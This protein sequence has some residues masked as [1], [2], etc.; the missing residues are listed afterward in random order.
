MRSKRSACGEIPVKIFLKIEILT[1]CINHSINTSN[2]PDL[3]KK[4]NIAQAFKRDESLD[5]LN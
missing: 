5:Q 2:F 3:L 1:D 4:A